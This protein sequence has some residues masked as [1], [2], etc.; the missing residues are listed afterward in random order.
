MVGYD[1]VGRSLK[2]KRVDDAHR[3][4]LTHREKGF[5]RMSN[6]GRERPNSATATLAGKALD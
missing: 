5:V 1:V 4:S 3:D 6:K 2:W